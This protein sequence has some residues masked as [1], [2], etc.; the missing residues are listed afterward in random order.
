MRVRGA[1]GKG[2]FKPRKAGE[3]SAVEEAWDDQLKAN[4]EVVWYRYEG[5]KVRLADGTFYTPDF[6]VLGADGVLECHEVKQGRRQKDGQTLATVITD[7]A[8]VKLKVAAELYP[9]RFRLVTG[10]SLPKYAG[11]GWQWQ[12]EEV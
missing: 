12:V 7:G 11:G 10:C 3:R 6:I 9:F 1:Y 8:A 4:P 2:G 5:T